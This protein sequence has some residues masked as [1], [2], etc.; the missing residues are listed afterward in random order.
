MK[1]IMV[2]IDWFLPGSKAGGPVRSL[3]NLVDY[4]DEEFEFLIITRNTD[5]CSSVPYPNIEAD[6][7]LGYGKNAKVFYCSAD[8][9]SVSTLKLLVKRQEPDLIYATGIYSFYF[10]LL[11]VYLGRK[12]KIQTIV[13]PRG[14][15]SPQSF[16][17]KSLKKTVFYSLFRFFKFYKYVRFHATAT[18]EVDDI[19]KQTQ[20][21]HIVY[22]PNLPRK[23][24]LKEVPERTKKSGELRLVA[25]SRISPEKNTFFAIECLKGCHGDITFDIYGAVYD[26]TYFR[27]CKALAST[28]PDSI[29]VNFMDA[30]STDQV[31]EI[32]SKY[33]FSFLPTTGENFGHSILESFAAHTP[34]IISD[35]T[36]WK[37]LTT[38]GLGADIPLDRESRFVK[39]LQIAVEIEGH[40][41]EKYTE[42]C[43]SFIE[44][45][46]ANVDLEPYRRLFR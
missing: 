46:Y 9:L 15:M 21:R 33:H 27:Q 39:A 38:K 4:L 31:L 36:P 37:D 34:V 42:S 17:S 19:V 18:N 5:Y 26:E 11:P 10:S 13:A 35:R 32:V 7:W 30:V 24:V 25:M 20:I 28:L 3:A 12:L 44:I 23:L 1:K 2:F 22:A 41:Y 45:Y 14:M 40:L 6:Q 16:S 43:R 8:N 29:K